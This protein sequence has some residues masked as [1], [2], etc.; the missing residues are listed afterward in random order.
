[1]STKTRGKLIGRET[2]LN[3]MAARA[4]AYAFLSRSLWDEP[5]K[6]YFEV[7]I[8]DELLSSFPFI[9]ESALIKEGVDN[10]T[11]F[12]RDPNLLSQDGVEAG[13]GEYN[14]LFFGFEKELRVS[15]YESVN[16]SPDKLVF[17]KETM[18]VRE[19]YAKYELRPKKFQREPDD[20]IGLELE[21]MQKLC[22][23]CLKDIRASRFHKA[24]RVMR[25]Q[26]SF[27]EDHLLKW[28]PALG[29]K[30]TDTATSDFYRGAGRILTGFLLADK[31]LASDLLDELS[32]R[33]KSHRKT[34]EEKTAG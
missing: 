34:K 26:L 24:K 14:R 7:L 10:I 21:F 22:E 23:Q 17:Q 1:M 31:E 5:S 25:D 33:I 11:F 28:A 16:L 19:A 13:K 9:D 29:Q 32:E 27:L 8:E 20:H 2:L 15:P 3:I 6:E 18:A 30:I 12:L 4:F